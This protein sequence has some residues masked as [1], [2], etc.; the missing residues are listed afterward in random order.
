MDLRYNSHLYPMPDYE[1]APQD[2]LSNAE[3][4]IRRPSVLDEAEW[5]LGS[6][7]VENIDCGIFAELS[8]LGT[9][10]VIVVWMYWMYCSSL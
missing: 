1:L 9:T 8:D 10:E 3:L 2:I 7:D 6:F 5:D 4:D